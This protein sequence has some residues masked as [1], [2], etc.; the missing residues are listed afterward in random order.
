VP[1][2]MTERPKNWRRVD[3]AWASRNGSMMN[4]L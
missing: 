4:E 1:T 3:K 2:P